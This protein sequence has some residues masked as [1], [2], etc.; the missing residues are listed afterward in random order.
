MNASQEGVPA[1]DIDPAE[2]VLI[3]ADTCVDCGGP[4]IDPVRRRGYR[5]RCFNC[6]SKA[7]YR[8]D[9]ERQRRNMIKHLYNLTHEQF[10]A[11]V[12]DQC[13]KCTICGHVP[14]SPYDFHVD[15]DH[16]CCP[17]K[18]SCGKCIRGLLCDKCN[19]GLGYFGDDPQVLR[20][21]ADYVARV[22]A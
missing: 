12:E 22:I 7:L 15:H 17:G 6:Y 4:R 2:L 10:L 18:K 13:G 21:A 5:Y 9:P 14:E 8:R 3:P 20:Q 1:V 11:R 16:R 19:R